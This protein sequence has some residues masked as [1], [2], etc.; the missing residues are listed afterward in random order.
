MES[1]ICYAFPM[2]PKKIGI[3]LGFCFISFHSNAQTIQELTKPAEISTLPEVLQLNNG[4]QVKSKQDWQRRRQE[5]LTMYRDLMYGSIPKFDHKN[6]QF[7]PVLSEESAGIYSDAVH[8]DVTVKLTR[9]HKVPTKVLTREISFHLHIPKSATKAK[10]APV[11]LAISF[12]DNSKPRFMS[13]SAMKTLLSKG[14]AVAS[15]YF[16]NIVWDSK[17][18]F[19]SGI[20]PLFYRDNQST[21][22]PKQ[23]GAISTWA[24]FIHK[25]VDYVYKE[26]K[27]SVFLPNSKKNFEIHLSKSQIAVWGLSRLGKT[28]LWAAAQDERIN[29]ILSH[30]GGTGGGA[31]LRYPYLYENVARITKNF[32]YWFSGAFRDFGKTGTAKDLPFDTHMLFSLMAPRPVMVTVQADDPWARR[33]ATYLSMKY[34]DPVYKF[35]GSEGYGKSIYPGN[36]NS[37]ELDNTLLPLMLRS[38]PA[39]GH[40]PSQADWNHNIRFLEKYFSQKNPPTPAR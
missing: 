40:Y 28:S 3:L 15:V 35:L 39:G 20:Y 37:Q 18:Q 21:P 2:F 27:T 22:D 26:N 19:L 29:V 5:I 14:I 33:N 34:A 25:M 38:R 23:M 31:L 9:P 11:L 30:A 32:G 7:T 12:D 24:W 1:A 13:S 17:N 16:E 6:I 8:L 10:P 36:L 4:R